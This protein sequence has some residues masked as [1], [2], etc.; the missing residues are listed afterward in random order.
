MVFG[1]HSCRKE[2]IRT[3]LIS[4]YVGFSFKSWF[5]RLKKSILIDLLA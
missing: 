5:G 2:T 1:V 4:N 3:K